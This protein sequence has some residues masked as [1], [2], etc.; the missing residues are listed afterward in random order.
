MTELTTTCRR[1]INAS[2]ERLYNAWLNPETIKQFMAPGAT[3]FVREAQSDAR[4]G[5]TFL[6]VMVHDKDIP[7]SGTYLALDPFSRMVFTWASPHSLPDSEVEITFTPVATGTE[8]VLT[9]TRFKSEQSRDGHTQG[10]TGILDKLAQQF[11]AAT[12]TA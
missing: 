9:H 11:G 2:A 12:T 5:G 6:V 7:H 10:W 3:S 1:T 8:V 4:V